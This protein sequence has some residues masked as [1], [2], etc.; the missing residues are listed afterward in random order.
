[1]SSTV[2]RLGNLMFLKSGLGFGHRSFAPAPHLG[3]RRSYFDSCTQLFH[4]VIVLRSI[5]TWSG[6]IQIYLG[7][8]EWTLTRVCFLC[9]LVHYW[10]LVPCWHNS[11]LYYFV[12]WSWRL[13]L[14]L[15]WLFASSNLDQLCFALLYIFDDV[16]R[17][18]YF[19]FWGALLL[20]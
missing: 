15:R 8:K 16:I 17:C 14:S 9:I 5:S 13:S 7:E 4:Q 18:S 6:L 12:L 10:A 2:T 3:H 11:F 20:R 19:F 1:M